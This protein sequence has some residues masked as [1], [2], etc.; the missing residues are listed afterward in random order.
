[1]LIILDNFAWYA[2]CLSS[3]YPNKKFTDNSSLV[4]VPKYDLVRSYCLSL[5]RNV[6]YCCWQC[7]R[8]RCGRRWSERYH[9]VFRSSLAV[10]I[11]WSVCTVRPHQR[12]WR[13]AVLTSSQSEVSSDGLGPAAAAN[14]RWDRRTSPHGSNC[15]CSEARTHFSRG[16]LP[17]MV[18]VDSC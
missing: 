15:W 17:Q 13:H 3:H 4:I 2:M 9:I 18:T 11:D 6:L 5:C 1:M 16:N 8:R 10:V 7:W 14:C 12:T